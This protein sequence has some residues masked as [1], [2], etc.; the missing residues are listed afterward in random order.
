MRVLRRALIATAAVAGLVSTA[1]AA[2]LAY[3]VKA[4]VMAAPVYSWSGV[5]GG[6]FGGGA[7]ADPRNYGLVADPGAGQTVVIGTAAN[8]SAPIFSQAYNNLAG[9]NTIAAGT[10]QVSNTIIPGGT[11]CSAF[12]NCAPVGPITAAATTITPNTNPGFRTDSMIPTSQ[13]SSQLAGLIGVEIGARKQFDNNFVLGIGADIM[14]FSRGGSTTSNSS[15]SFFN[16]NGFTGN[17]QALGCVSDIITP[18]SCATLQLL[19]TSGSVATVNSG[20]SMSSL[21]VAANPNWIGTVRGS[22]GYAFDRVLIFGSAGLAYSDGN[23][24]VTGSYNDRVSSACS[25]VSNV[26][27]PST[28]AGNP[29]QSFVGFQCGGAPTTTIP[30]SASVSQTT[31]TSVTYTGNRGGM[32]T[33]FAAGAGAAYA[34]SD[35]VSLT[36]EGMYYNLGTE[37][38]TVTGSGTQTT[39]TTVLGA[40]N[41][42]AGAGITA[43]P[44]STTT[45]VNPNATASSFTVSKMID[46]AIFKGGV[47]F[48]F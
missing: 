23:M 38:V 9:T 30:N 14:G 19:N 25:G 17:S 3:K 22:L 1:S 27:T 47:Q 10:G 37:R 32:L 36:F 8:G 39:T 44:N 40:T 13:N 7:F 33:G 34:I 16:S 24:K 48:K 6:G 21:T 42:I 15:G 29:G 43:T 28:N 31:T 35:H 45:V 11:N 5:Y 41:T 20:G 4:P 2:D 18:N 26:I 12:T 46:G